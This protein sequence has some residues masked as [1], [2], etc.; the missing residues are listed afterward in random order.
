MTQWEAVQTRISCRAYQETLLPGEVL[1]QLE[2]KIAALNAAS[3][4]RF[5]L[6]V[7]RDPETPAVK[8]AGAMFSGRVYCCAALFGGEDDLS[9]E[10]VG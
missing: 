8:L 6:C 10:K 5:C 4:L 2:E 1:G 3:G 9:A 7:S